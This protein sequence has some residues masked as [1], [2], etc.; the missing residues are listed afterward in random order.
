MVQPLE[1]EQEP[2]ELSR[3]QTAGRARDVTRGFLTMLEPRHAEE[4]DAVLLVVSELVTNAVRHAGGVTRFQLTAGPGVLAVSV[5]DASLEPPREL[6]SEVWEPGGFGWE[7]VRELSAEVQVRVHPAQGK[8]VRA[9][10]PLSHTGSPPR[11]GHSTS[12]T[13]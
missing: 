1:E 11:R 10:I 2:L 13:V 6:R 7:M 12:S 3:P 8:S 5:E 9:V 4:A